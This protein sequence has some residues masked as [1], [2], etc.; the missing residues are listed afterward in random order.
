MTTEHP[1]HRGDRA[2]NPDEFA[3][4]AEAEDGLWWFRGMRNILYRVLD[5]FARKRTIRRVLEVGCGTGY[6]AV[7]FERRYGWSVYPLDIQREGLAYAQNFQATRLTQGD[8]LSLP[9][10]PGVFDVLVCLDVLIHLVPGDEARALAEFARVLA[11]GGLLILRVAALSA[12]RS[13]HSQFVYERQRFTAARLTA[14]VQN[15]GI[16]VA[17]R[18]YAN[19]L[20]L[21][22]ALLKFR[23]WEVLLRRAPESGVRPMAGWLNTLLEVPL[24][25]E[26]RWLGAGLNLPLG[27]SLILVGAKVC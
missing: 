25:M 15:Q 2:M 21:P 17:R 5:P 14:A 3:N 6:N 24:A 7:A 1:F 13:R 8:A 22:V 27:Q 23:V 11:P 10:P 4:I 18:T 20:L 16:R 9:F 26:S 12:C 19:M